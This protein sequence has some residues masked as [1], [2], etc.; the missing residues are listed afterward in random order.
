VHTD[1]RAAASARAVHA[2]AY[3]VGQD[4]VFDTGRYAPWT[5]AGRGL[6]AHELAHTVQQRGVGRPQAGSGYVVSEPADEHELAADRMARR[7]LSSSG[8]EQRGRGLASDLGMP[9]GAPPSLQRRCS[10]HGNEAFYAAAPNYCRDTG[11]SGSLHPGQRCYREVPRRTS[12]FQCPPGD[13]V[14][15]DAQGTCHDSFD[16]VSPVES[17]DADGS[18]NLHWTCM[19][20]HGFADVIPPVMEDVGRRQIECMQSCETLP[21]YLKGFCMQGC[22]GGPM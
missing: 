4:I 14:C 8:T 22:S 20:G 16:E 1:A 3:T 5:D 17:R 21:W 2:L 15:F 13:Q 12:Y 6:L 9:A 10:D 19:I 11:F 7:G 18:C